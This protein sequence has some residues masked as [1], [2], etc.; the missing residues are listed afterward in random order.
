MFAASPLQDSGYPP[1][2]REGAYVP[3]ATQNFFKSFGLAVDLV[4]WTFGISQYEVAFIRICADAGE[5]SLICF[6]T[7]HGFFITYFF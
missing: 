4:I 6:H 3:A 1:S 7:F 2:T 5:T